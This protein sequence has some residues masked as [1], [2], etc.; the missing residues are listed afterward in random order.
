MREVT[1]HKV[2]AG[3]YLKSWFIIDILS[4]VPID[5]FLSHALLDGNQLLR[6]LRIGKLYKMM[7]LFR[8]V[9]ALK[10]LKN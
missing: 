9:R 2:I 3:K 7:R 5:L 4:V 6:V 8:M 1:D 10:L